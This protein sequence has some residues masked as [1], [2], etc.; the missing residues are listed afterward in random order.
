MTLKNIITKLRYLNYDKEKIKKYKDIIDKNNFEILRDVSLII[1]IVYFF[2]FLF[3]LFF[4]RI[5]ERAIGG[6]IMG[7]LL[8]GVHSYSAYVIKNNIRISGILINSIIMITSILC[9]LSC[10]YLGTFQS[11][12]DLAVTII[13]TFLF[14]PIVFNLMPVQN[15]II[16]PCA[17]IF[18]YCSYITKDSVRFTY[19]TIHTIIIVFV[20]MFMSWNKSK[21]KIDYIDAN[22]KLY[23]AS[24]TDELTGLYNRRKIFN[25]LE[26]IKTECISENK[27]MFCLVM[28][29]DD[30]K[31]YNDLYGHPKGDL[32]LKK[33]GEKLREYSLLNDIKIGR[34]GGEEFLVVWKEKQNIN[35]QY[36]N[37][38]LKEQGEFIAEEIRLIIANLNITHKGSKVSDIVTVSQGLYIADIKN[39]FDFENAYILADMEL[40]KAKKQGKNCCYIKM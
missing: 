36:K 7:V 18:I 8:L 31:A 5:L 1:S 24:A 14:V 25:K 21:Q 26:K 19:D 22:E 15:L 16:I 2:V 13:W 37:L 34:I 17:I 38:D 20:G 27:S 40:Y 4:N 32:L 33:I 9:Y 23:Y 11:R 39:K 29:I 10:I 6:F 35:N 3:F 12:N 30:F 28:D